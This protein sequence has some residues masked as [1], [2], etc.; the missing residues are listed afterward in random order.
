MAFT[1]SYGV[2]PSPARAETLPK[3][4]A[5]KKPTLHRTR[6]DNDLHAQAQ[7]LFDPAL[8]QNSEALSPPAAMDVPKDGAALLIPAEEDAAAPSTH[9]LAMQQEHTSG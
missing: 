4:I 8:A 7:A 2:T 1:M 5:P 6:K 3:V 9:G